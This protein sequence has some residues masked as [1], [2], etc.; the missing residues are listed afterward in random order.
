[1]KVDLAEALAT[2]DESFHPLPLT[3]EERQL[4]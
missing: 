2:V 4:R 3:R 1:M